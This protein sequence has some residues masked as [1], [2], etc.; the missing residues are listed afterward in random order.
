MNIHL[1]MESSSGRQREFPVE[2]P[3]TVLGRG[4]KCDL[5]IPLQKVSREH[6]QIE[7]RH[8]RAYL[9]DLGSMN[10]TFVNSQKI[11]EETQ[12]HSGDVIE[13]ASIKFII[14]ILFHLWTTT[15]LTSWFNKRPK[16]YF[17]FKWIMITPTNRNA[18]MFYSL[19]IFNLFKYSTRKFF[20]I[21]FSFS[22]STSLIHS[23]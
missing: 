20:H 12:L 13:I 18:T 8:G 9:E 3:L 6:C 5:R 2:N 10:G 11:E 22:K 17:M 14:M 16:P 23:S 15:F 19:I 21:F 1:T 4:H 7:L